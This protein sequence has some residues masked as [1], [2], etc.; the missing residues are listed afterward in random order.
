[1]L[2]VVDKAPMVSSHK[3]RDTMSRSEDGICLHLVS[4]ASCQLA[5]TEP[6][7]R[8]HHQI[9]FERT[10]LSGGLLFMPFFF[11]FLRR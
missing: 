5:A 2:T 10:H 11:F 8:C 7:Q 1:M 6:S 3:D 4:W 9:E